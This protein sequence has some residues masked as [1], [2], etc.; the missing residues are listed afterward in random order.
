MRAINLGSDVED[1]INGYQCTGQT[2]MVSS[3]VGGVLPDFVIP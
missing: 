1:A 2:E 3:W